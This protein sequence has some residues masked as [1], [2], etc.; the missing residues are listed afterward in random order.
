V[1]LVS[2]ACNRR[3]PLPISVREE[4]PKAEG[5]EWEALKAEGG[6]GGAPK[7]EEYMRVSL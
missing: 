1:L 2:A 3:V 7:D 6:V 5:S 4:L